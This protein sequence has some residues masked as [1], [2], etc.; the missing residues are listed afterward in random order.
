MSPAWAQLAWRS[1][2]IVLV[3]VWFLGLIGGFGAGGLLHLL[4]LAAAAVFGYQLR[5]DVSG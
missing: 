5:S 3:L 2:P 1:L 4:L